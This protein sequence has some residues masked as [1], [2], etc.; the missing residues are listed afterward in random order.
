MAPKDVE[1]GANATGIRKNLRAIFIAVIVL[2]VVIVTSVLVYRN[3]QQSKAT[4]A[5]FAAAQKE[6]ATSETSYKESSQKLVN[7]ADTCKKS[8]ESYNLCSTL[9]Q[10]HEDIAAGY[11]V[12]KEEVDTIDSNNEESLDDAIANLKSATSTIQEL[13]RKASDAV[14]TYEESLLKAVQDEHSNLLDEAR[15]NLKEAKALL[16]ASE[17][18]TSDEE[19]WKAFSRILGV[20]EKELDKNAEV[21]DD[22]VDAHIAS[23][24]VLRVENA[25]I[26]SATNHLKS[27]YKGASSDS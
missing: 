23:S 3:N 26:V 17:G 2:V 9:T 16:S 21:K 13:D 22:D 20:Y 12:V 14:T 27:I 25:A 7:T 15:T 8:Y 24:E 18:K 6:F 11:S 5:E 10:A 1:K 19:L 4:H